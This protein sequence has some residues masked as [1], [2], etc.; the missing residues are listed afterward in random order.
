MH[1]YLRPGDERSTVTLG[2]ACT[3]PHMDTALLP[4]QLPLRHPL[5][6]RIPLLCA[7]VLHDTS[8]RRLF[9]QVG[10]FGSDVLSKHST[11]L[12]RLGHVGTRVRVLYAFSREGSPQEVVG[13]LSLGSDNRQGL[14]ST[15]NLLALDF[16]DASSPLLRST[17][18]RMVRL[19]DDCCHLGMSWLWPVT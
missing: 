4:T 8:S 2:L 6:D 13:V 1:L 14:E 3:I 10:I 17:G 7:S 12:V 11:R 9:P 16:D 5:P 18:R 15:G 19:C